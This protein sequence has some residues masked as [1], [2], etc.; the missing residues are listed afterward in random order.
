MPT[1]KPKKQKKKELKGNW[2]LS[3]ISEHFTN[4]IGAGMAQKRKLIKQKRSTRNKPLR[5]I[6]KSD[7]KFKRAKKTDNDK[8]L[9]H[10]RYN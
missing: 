6:L 3:N 10:F 4:V 5:Y 2:V 1:K 8:N 7:G 9:I